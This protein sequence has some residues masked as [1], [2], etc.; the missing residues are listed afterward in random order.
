MTIH[1]REITPKGS[2]LV[3]YFVCLDGKHLCRFSVPFHMAN[4]THLERMAR[5][6][7]ERRPPLAEIDR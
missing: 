5:T 6:I 3:E 1:I 7:V 4:P 2:K